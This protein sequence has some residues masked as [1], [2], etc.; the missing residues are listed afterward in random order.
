MACAGRSHLPRP[1]R[2]RSPTVRSMDRKPSGKRRSRRR[3]QRNRA[4]ADAIPPVRASPG[5]GMARARAGPG[6]PRRRRGV[7]RSN[8]RRGHQPHQWRSVQQLATVGGRNR[9][10][11]IGGGGTAAQGGT[12]ADVTQF[13]LGPQPPLRL[14]MSYQWRA[15]LEKGFGS[16]ESRR[17]HTRAPRANICWATRLTWNPVPGSERLV[18][19]TTNSSNYQALAVAIQRFA[20]T[21]RLRLGIVHLV[22]FHRRWLAGIPPSF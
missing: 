12:G 3:H 7:L 13:L 15:S 17:S 4:L 6:V 8:T 16:Q 11:R 10:G 19:L 21:E 2:Y 9:S 14:P 5:T 1:A 20:G 18:T 22:A